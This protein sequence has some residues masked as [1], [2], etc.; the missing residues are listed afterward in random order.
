MSLD[1]LGPNVTDSSDE[2][3]LSPDLSKKKATVKF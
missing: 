2:D 1:E 3:D